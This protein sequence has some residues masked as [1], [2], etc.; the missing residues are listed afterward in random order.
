MAV[1]SLPLAD[2]ISFKFKISPLSPATQPF[3]T[4][5]KSD[6]IIIETHLDKTIQGTGRM[7]E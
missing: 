2:M 5:D 3:Q 7:R 4:P 6:A 1:D